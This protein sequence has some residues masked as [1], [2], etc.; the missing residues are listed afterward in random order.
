MQV[1]GRV[2]EWTLLAVLWLTLPLSPV[3]LAIIAG[4]SRYLREWFS[5]TRQMALSLRS[6]ARASVIARRVGSYGKRTARENAAWQISGECS[7]CGNCCLDRSCVFLSYDGNGHS[8]CG[9]YGNWFFRRLT[10]GGYPITR[11]D[12]RIYDC[13]SFHASPRDS[14]HGGVPS[15]GAGLTGRV[16][17]IVARSA[18]EQPARRS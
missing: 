10:C 13:P 3:A 7:H 12:I 6:M 2:I 15:S 5:T 18:V 1:L 9:I 8:R 11:D 16:I 4:D 14:L 17:P